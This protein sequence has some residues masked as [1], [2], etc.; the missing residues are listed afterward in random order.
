[1]SRHTHRTTRQDRPHLIIAGWDRPL[2]HFF[3]DVLDLAQPQEDPQHT[4]YRTMED[5]SLMDPSRGTFWMGLREDEL[6]AKVA[7]LDLCLPDVMLAQLRE[8]A[9]SNAGNV[10]RSF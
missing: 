9:R 1:M 10:C 2:G 7:E 5:L 8:D 6:L 4:V 3:L